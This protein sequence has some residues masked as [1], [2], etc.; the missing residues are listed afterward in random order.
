[1]VVKILGD[2]PSCGAPLLDILDENNNVVSFLDS[3]SAVS[4]IPTLALE[5]YKT[6]TPYRSS[7]WLVHGASGANLNVICE[8]TLIVSLS[9]NT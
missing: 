6:A 2:V 7:P 8:L 3:G 9:G 5:K 4:I 1:M